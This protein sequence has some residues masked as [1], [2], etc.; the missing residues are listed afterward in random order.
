HFLDPHKKY[1][2]HPGFSNFGSDPR[3]LYDGE[4]AFTDHHIGRVLKALAESPAA[5]RT[6]V[7]FTGDHGE[8]FGEHGFSFHRRGIWDGVVRIPLFVYVPGAEPHSISRRVSS[9]DIVPTILDLAGLPPDAEARGQ[10][11]VPEIFGE[12]LAPRPVLVDQPRN[13]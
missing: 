12:K 4:I 2:E 6:A 11:L 5:G 9:V 10:S 13:P 8:A 3:A 1:L 7:I